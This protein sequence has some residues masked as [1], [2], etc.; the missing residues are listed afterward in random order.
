MAT[1]RSQYARPKADARLVVDQAVSAPECPRPGHGGR[2]VWPNGT[3][4]TA[5]GERPTFAAMRVDEAAYRAGGLPVVYFADEVP[6]KRDCA[7]SAPLTSAPVVWTALVVTRTSWERDKDGKVTGR[8]S[9]VVRVRAPSNASADA[10]RLVLAELD[11]PD[12][13]VIDGAA[14]I[15]KAARP[16]RPGRPGRARP[17]LCARRPTPN[18]ARRR[19]RT[20]TATSSTACPTPAELGG[21]AS[22]GSRRLMWPGFRGAPGRPGP[23]AA[24]QA[25]Y[26]AA[27]SWK[28]TVANPSSPR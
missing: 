10:W 23:E 9:R 4:K 12:F 15:E 26:T 3:Y 2:Y 24:E 5:A 17:P 7:R 1:A 11:A 27:T 8:S 14:A 25:T 18:S 19:A 28:T 20:P 13:L 21:K 22:L 6:V 16:Q